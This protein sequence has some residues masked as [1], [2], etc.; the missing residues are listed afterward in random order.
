MP[1][2]W[3]MTNLCADCSDDESHKVCSLGTI[4]DM[5]K[6]GRQITIIISRQRTRS[7]QNITQKPNLWYYT[8]KYL[9][10]QCWRRIRFRSTDTRIPERKLQS[11][12]CCFSVKVNSFGQSRKLFVFSGRGRSKHHVFPGGGFKTAFEES[13]GRAA[14]VSRVA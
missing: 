4:L 7:F 12:H 11:P 14:F 9:Q 10:Q 1:N 3:S 6:I 8:L 13:L 5:L 2:D